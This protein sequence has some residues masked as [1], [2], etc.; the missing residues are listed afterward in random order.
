MFVICDLKF[1]ILMKLI[2]GLGNPGKQYVDTRHNVG[3][4]I[5]DKFLSRFPG[6]P[7]ISRK[8]QAIYY[9]MRIS[10]D[11]SVK[12]ILAKPL[13]YM[14]ESG[15]AV[16]KLASFFKI[17]LDDL[18]VIHD[19]IDLK[20]GSYRIQKGRGS[21]GHKGVQSIIDNLSSQ[22]FTR[23]RVGV[24]RPVPGI[25]PERYVLQRFK[26]YERK[27]LETVLEPL[28]KEIENFISK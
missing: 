10:D 24:N 15:K 4:Y 3:F 21:A 12:V 8:L 2:V 14:N 9:L 25:D 17:K 23:L 7:H 22:E 19:D 6:F 27:S 18:I 1:E 16:K 13:A 28:L 5:I 20:I 11:R 26:D